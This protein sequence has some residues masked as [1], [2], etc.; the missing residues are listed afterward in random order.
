M[1]SAAVPTLQG[2]DKSRLPANLRPVTPLVKLTDFTGNLSPGVKVAQ[3]R[4]L[5]LN[6]VST[7]D[8]G[9]AAV[10][11]NNSYFEASLAIPG[12][13]KIAGGPTEIPVEGTTEVY[14]IINIS[15]DAH[16]MHIHLLQWQLVS[17]QV[18]DVDGYL[19]TISA[20]S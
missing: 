19:G 20:V 7:T 6:E 3:K 18:I 12:T 1:V 5:V 4:Q 16:P 13:P 2:R 10:L 15:A 14:Q 11:V 9:P 8:G 17:R